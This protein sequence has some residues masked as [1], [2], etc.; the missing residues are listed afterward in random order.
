MAY[1]LS[2]E[3]LGRVYTGEK[4]ETVEYRLVYRQGKKKTSEQYQVF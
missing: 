1:T 3:N 4:R 2:K